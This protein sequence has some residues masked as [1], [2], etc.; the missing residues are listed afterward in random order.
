MTGM[1]HLSGSSKVD[2]APDKA[3][4]DIILSRPAA[5]VREAMR[6]MKAMEVPH[7]YFN[8]EKEVSSAIAVLIE[9]IRLDYVY[10]DLDT[11]TRFEQEKRRLLSTDCQEHIKQCV[12]YISSRLGGFIRPL[13]HSRSRK[14][15]GPQ[16]VIAAFCSWAISIHEASA[17]VLSNSKNNYVSTA[18]VL[19]LQLFRLKHDVATLLDD[20][21]S[22]PVQL[23]AF[24]F[25]IS[26]SNSCGKKKSMSARSIFEVLLEAIKHRHNGSISAT[27]SDF[28]SRSGVSDNVI[29]IR[30]KPFLLCLQ[31]CGKSVMSSY[32]WDAMINNDQ[33]LAFAVLE[34][35]NKQLA[36]FLNLRNNALF[37]LEDANGIENLLSYRYENVR[38][39]VENYKILQT[40]L[41]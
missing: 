7:L 10:A 22:R 36:T 41:R 11:T 32:I 30:S 18:G 5:L 8:D 6:T 2:G 15:T 37:M 16:A 12:G 13:K 35:N 19:S 33:T 25:L 29:D 3:L 4:A 24:H 26:K 14:R 20:S 31:H 39:L 34:A 21:I 40:V 38:N 28:N 23:N 27:V 17:I 9:R 1:P